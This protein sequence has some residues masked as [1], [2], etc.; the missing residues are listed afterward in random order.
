MQGESKEVENAAD[1][2]GRTCNRYEAE[3]LFHDPYQHYETYP[4]LILSCLRKLIQKL[5][6]AGMVEQGSGL[7]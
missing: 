2:G 5:Y 7:R 4:V 3:V 6:E 1:T